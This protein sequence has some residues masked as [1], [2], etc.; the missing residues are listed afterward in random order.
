MTRPLIIVG[1]GGHA[2]VVADA[3]LAAGES[4]LGFTD[5]NSACHGTTVCGCPVL[6][7]DTILDDYDP[8]SVL[9]ANGIGT[10]G[11]GRDRLRREIHAR[12]VAAGLEFVTVR[13]PASVVSRFAS[14]SPGAQL[15]ASSVIQAGATIGQGAIV[16]SAAVVE[17]DARIGDWTHIA[18]GAVVCGGVRVGHRCFV[19]AGA[20]VR[21]GLSL[22]D[23]TV[24][25]AGAV[26]L[27]DFPAGGTL[28]GVPARQISTRI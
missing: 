23:D 11:S 10:T 6:G 13:H 28:I 7:D 9:L 16:N 5:L 15:F 2:S 18:P 12:L 22:G 20:V 27:Q 17:H 1:A 25:G 14:I 26:V 8:G 21:H 4:V 19:G 3:V 24:V